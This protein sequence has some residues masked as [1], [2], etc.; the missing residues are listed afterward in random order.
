MNLI[1][2]IGLGDTYLPLLLIFVYILLWKYIQQNDKFLIL[3]AVVFFVLYGATN[4]L[5]A[6]KIHN[7]FLYHVISLVE[8]IMVSYYILKLVLQKSFLFY[9]LIINV[10]YLFLWTGNIIFFEPLDV[11]NGNSA[12]LAD[13]IVLFLC[14]YYLLSLSAKEEI[15]YFQKLPAFWIVSGFLIYAALSLLVFISYGYISNEYLNKIATADQAN[16]MWFINSI[17]MVIK[18][19]L[20]VFGLLCYKRKNYTKKYFRSVL[21]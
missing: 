6:Y 8:L 10:A 14:M 19:V 20:I 5:G 7:L 18:Y 4:V 9:F 11:Y 13:L 15:L 3:Y 2:L 1:R 17:A 16:Q 12:V 21:F